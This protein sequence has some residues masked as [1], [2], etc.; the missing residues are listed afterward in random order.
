MKTIL[1]T[2]YTLAWS[3]ALGM[4]PGASGAELKEDLMFADDAAYAPWVGK[5]AQL[6]F[7]AVDDRAVDLQQMRGK[8][9]LL[10]FWATWCGPCV[11]E[12]P[13]VKAAY[14]IWHASGFE[15][16]GISFDDD[17]EALVSKVRLEQMMWP[18][19]FEGRQN[20]GVGQQFGIQHYPSMWLVDKRGIVRYI[21]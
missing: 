4:A 6:K 17:K 12:I 16:I 3:L 5:P 15:I 13:Q 18:Q 2:F 20:N 7:T 14:N 11:R 1:N 10:D 9:V 21:S 8:V 19:Y